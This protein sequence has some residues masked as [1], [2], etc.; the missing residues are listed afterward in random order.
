L[1]DEV[2]LTLK[3][4]TMICYNRYYYSQTPMVVI[5][6]GFFGSLIKGISSRVGHLLLWLRLLAM[7]NPPLEYTG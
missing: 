6:F 2:S 3:I 4:P 5:A 7:G 1:N